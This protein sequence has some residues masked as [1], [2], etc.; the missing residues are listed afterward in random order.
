[1]SKEKVVL[2]FS[3]GLDTS[4][5]LVW[6]REQGYEVITA[7]V[8]TGGMTNEE[9]AKIRA[10]AQELGSTK[11]LVLDARE[12][13]YD[14][15]IS[16]VLKG[17]YLRNGVYPSC[18]GTERRVQAE[19]IVKFALEEGA[20]AVAHGSTAAGGDHI[21][22]D[23]VIR[24]MAAGLDIITPVRDDELARE[25]STAYLRERGYAVEEKTTTY[26]I[27]IGLVGTTIGGGATYNSFDYLPEDAWPTTRAIVD[28]PD[29]PADLVLA[30]DQGLPV[31]CTYE[32]GSPIAG[33]EDA[34]QNYAVL[35]ALNALAAEHG[36][37]RGIHTGLTIMGNPARLGFEAPGVLTII[38]AHKELERTVLSSRQQVNKATLANTY[39]DMLHEGL[40]YD[41]LMED[42]EVFL[43]S[44]QRRV[45]GDVRVRLHKGN[46]IALGTRTPFSLIDVGRELGAKYG[47]SSTLWSGVDARSF[48]KV[49]SIGGA[50]AAAA[51]K[52][53][54]PAGVEHGK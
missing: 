33:T 26:S 24:T 20:S 1:M 17:N 54:A 53:D 2:A 9:E 32:D 6:L 23:V 46:V 52:A 13:L 7:V 16:Y 29:E 50:I 31:S 15:F 14:R 41:P 34:K 18:V 42:I 35:A 30:F 45:T 38:A 43:D 37:G 36:V 8:D 22:F 10:R 47:H 19:R 40:Y 49:Y 51:A 44:T 48:A 27:N 25:T 3:G 12:E 11:H 28:T 4:Y 39:G 21:R 5:C